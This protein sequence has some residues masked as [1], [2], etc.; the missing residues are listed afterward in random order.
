MNF[1]PV[2]IAFAM[3]LRPRHSLEH[4]AVAHTWLAD[5]RGFAG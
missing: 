3:I 5:E 4:P 1:P 2:K